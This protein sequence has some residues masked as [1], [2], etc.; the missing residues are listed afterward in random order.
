MLHRSSTEIRIEHHV[1]REG[2]RG[3]ERVDVEQ[4]GDESLFAEDVRRDLLEG[5]SEGLQVC[6]VVSLASRGVRDRMLC[7]TGEGE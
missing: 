2:D 3:V 5:G 7:D 6:S 4:V 1:I